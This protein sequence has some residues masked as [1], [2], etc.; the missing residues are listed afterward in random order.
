MLSPRRWRS[1]PPLFSRCADPPAR[2]SRP[3]RPR[4]R[5]RSGP[6][7]EA[8]RLDLARQDVRGPRDLP[9][10]DR[11]GGRPGGESRGRARDGDL[12]RVRRRLRQH[13]EVRGDGHRLLADA[14]GGRAAERL[15]PGGRD[16]RRGGARVHRRG[17]PG[18][19]RAV[20]PPRLRAGDEGAG[21]E[22]APR[23]ASGT[24]GSPT[25][26]AALAARRGDTAEARR[27]IAAARRALDG[28]TAMA[29][30]QERFFPYLIGYVALYLHD[31]P[32]AER[33]LTNA[34]NLRGNQRDPFMRCLLAMTLRAG[35]QD[36]RGERAVPP[37]LRPRHGAQSAGRVRPAVR[38]E[39][40]RPALS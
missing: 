20:V 24:S 35:G 13:G 21:A 4:P 9:A 1:A 38:A 16:G 30:Q 2:S 3:P 19:R 33:D 10:D 26:W 25:R 12:V 27:Q 32:A 36:G 17:R 14:R 18:R 29:A 5:G 37:G 28:D 11:F 34:L 31:L 7:Q 8:A 23:R 40:A 15:L 6:M 39:E 22:D